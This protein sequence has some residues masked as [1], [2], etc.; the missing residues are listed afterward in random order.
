M[1]SDD[2]ESEIAL[3][4]DFCAKERIMRFSNLNNLGGFMR[5][6]L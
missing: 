4:W 2:K 1:Q 3:D 6:I 5:L